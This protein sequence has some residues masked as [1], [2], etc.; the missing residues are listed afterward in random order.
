MQLSIIS[1]LIFTFLLKHH[2]VLPLETG[3]MRNRPFNELH[4]DGHQAAALLGERVFHTRRNLGIE[5]ATYQPI[6]FQRLQGVAQHFR[7]NVGD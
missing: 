5:V 3:E 2:A 1:K 4:Q 7:R 6:S